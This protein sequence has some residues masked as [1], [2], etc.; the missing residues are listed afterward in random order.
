MNRGRDPAVSV[1]A[2]PASGDLAARVARR[3]GA[4]LVRAEA[5]VFSDGETKLTLRGRVSTR[6]AVVVQ[7]MEPPVDTNMMAALSLVSAASEHA[8]MTVA[9][10]PYVAYARQDRAF[11]EGEVVTMGVVGRMLKAAGAARILTVDIHSRAGLRFLG[12]RARNV[13]AV[14]ALAAHFGKM[15][16]VGPMVVSPDAG[17]RGRAEEFAS[18]LGAPCIALEKKRDRRTGAVSIVTRDADV[19]GRDV[20][21][22]DDMISTGGSIIKAAGFLRKRGCRRVYAACTHALLLGDAAR[23]IRAAGV[24]RVV[25]TNTVGGEASAV[26]VSGVIAE[27][28]DCGAP[29]RRGPLRGPA[30][31]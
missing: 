25:G 11:L 23:K 24:T 19:S 14:G 22:V 20:I 17:G 28:I 12:T 13:S 2:G 3:L 4:G 31:R 15:K 7:S 16:L 18:H 10:I 27:G 29:P 9:V 8:R 21:L 6:C 5:R 1:V 30:G 26:D